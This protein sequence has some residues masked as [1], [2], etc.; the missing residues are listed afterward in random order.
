MN[1]EAVR[2]ALLVAA[3]TRELEAA[4]AEVARLQD[5]LR[6]ATERAPQ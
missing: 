2:L 5:E 6:R 1:E 4:R 3:R